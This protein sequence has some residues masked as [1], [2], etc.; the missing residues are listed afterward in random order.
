MNEIS[1][2]DR[3]FCFN[4]YDENKRNRVVYHYTSPDGLL[5]ILKTSSIRFT[6]CEYLNDKSEYN[7]IR[8][9]LDKAFEEV[10]D[11]LYNS[12]LPEMI[13]GYINAEYDYSELVTEKA[14]S[15]LKGIRFLNMRHFVFCASNDSDSLNMW[16]YYV[17]NGTYQ[18]YNIGLS[19]NDIVKLLYNKIGKYGKLFYGQV[20]YSDK[21]KIEILKN[22]IVKVDKDL[23]NALQLNDDN[24]EN[25]LIVQEHYGD[26]ISYIENYRL[27]FKDVAFSGERE[28][29]FVLRLSDDQL[30]NSNDN[31]NI[32]YCIKQGIVTPYYDMPF[33]K[34]GIIKGITISPMIEPQLA[35]SGLHRFLKDYEY[36]SKIYIDFSKIPIRY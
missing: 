27:F 31:L 15:G 4:P 26:L 7:H 17:K 14:E 32:S 3:I 13:E 18:G 33:D 11:K 30:M 10:R 22:I 12:D 34:T 20:I 8:I 19:V 5:A 23:N 28:Y 25:D 6:D 16:N 21:E 36:N 2:S 29:R 1:F 35:K 9:P 24:E